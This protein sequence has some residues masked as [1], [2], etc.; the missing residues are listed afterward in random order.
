MFDALPASERNALLGVKGSISPSKPQPIVCA[1]S[2]EANST[3]V[4][5]SDD[6][7]S[8]MT[9]NPGGDKNQM[10]PRKPGRARAAID[11]GKV[12]KV[13]LSIYLLISWLIMLLI[14]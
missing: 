5:A 3:V 8:E 13:G 9:T 6:Q 7:L 4:D 2:N 1:S 12:A 14:P 11:P 10:T